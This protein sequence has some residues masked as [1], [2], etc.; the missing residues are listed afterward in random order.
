MAHEDFAIVIGISRYAYLRC[1]QGPVKDAEDFKEWLIKA[2]E[3][4]DSHIKSILSDDP[5]N[6]GDRP[7]HAEIDR[8]FL[9]VFQEARQCQ[10]RRLYVY[11]AG[12][13]CSA[14]VDHVALLMASATLDTL[15]DGLNAVSYHEGLARRA[16]FP[17]QVFFYDCCRNYERRAHG[18]IPIWTYDDPAPG[19]ENV[20]QLILYASGFTQYAY[21]RAIH[22]SE[23]RGLFTKALLEGL[24]GKAPKRQGGEWVVTSESLVPYVTQRLEELARH[25]GLRQNLSRGP[26]GRV[27]ELVLARVNPPLQKVSV[28]SGVPGGEVVVK[29]ENMEEIEPRVPLVE[30]KAELELIP[31]LYYIV[32]EPGNSGR[33]V[34]VGGDEAIAV[35]L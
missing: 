15:N 12:H 33:V 32:V 2:A 18:R 34:S 23:R 17:E 19:A 9:E 8:A 28:T 25:E 10:A 21:E 5:P 11:F 30:G 1:L 26:V 27:R 24:N 14:E 31:G 29:D 16:L 7:I 13:G 6:P 20:T 4:K 35:S 22:Y 3:V